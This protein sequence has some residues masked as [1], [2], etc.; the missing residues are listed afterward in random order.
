MLSMDS[1]TS[2]TLPPTFP[3]RGE[4][5]LEIPP[6]FSLTPGRYSLEV[7]AFVQDELADHIPGALEFEVQEG[8]FFGNGRKSRDTSAVLVKTKWSI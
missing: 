5:T 7:C 8:D 4:L 3:Q 2:A 1:R 6:D